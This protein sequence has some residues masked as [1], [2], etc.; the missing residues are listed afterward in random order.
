MGAREAMLRLRFADDEL[1]QLYQTRAGVYDLLTSTTT[2]FSPTGSR[3]HGDVHRLDALGELNEQLDRRIEEISDMRLRAIRWIYHLDDPLQRTVLMAYY[4]NC[5]REDGA[6]V[7]WDDVAETV[8][9]SR[10]T[11]LRKHEAAL[12]G[13]DMLKLDE[14]DSDGGAVI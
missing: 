2:R 3:A 12:A 10:S 4:V 1:R 13:L 5:R 7:S 8:H 11:A 6:L 9:V 14:I